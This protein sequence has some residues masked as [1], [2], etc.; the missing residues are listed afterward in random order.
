MTSIEPLLPLTPSLFSNEEWK[1]I[2]ALLARLD[3]S[4]RLWLSGYLLS[5]K[6]EVFTVDTTAEA[7]AQSHMLV[8][9]GT[10]TGN[11]K[12]LAHQLAEQATRAGSSVQLV[13]LA[14]YRFRQLMHEEMLFIICSTHG[15]GDAPEPIGEFYAALMNE[16][17]ASLH[18]LTFAVL[19]LGDTSYPLFCE[20]G[21]NIEQRL[22]QLGAKPAI[23]RVDCDVDYQEAAEQWINQVIEHLPK[24]PATQT[25]TE[26]A[27]TPVLT[28]DA[29][30]E[31]SK[32]NPCVAKVIENIP[33]T[34]TTSDRNVHHLELALPDGNLSLK[35]GDAIGI[36]AHNSNS[37]ITDIFQLTGLDETADVIINQ[38]S[39]TL[40]E[41]LQTQVDLVIPGKKFL[42]TWAQWCQDPA[43][44]KVATADFTEQRSFLRN[45]QII[46]ILLEYPAAPAAQEF[47][48]IL[49]PLQ[50]RLYD[51]ANHINNDHE[52]HIL[53]KQY[54][55]PFRNR[56]EKGMASTWL[57]TLAAEDTVLIYPHVNKK[58]HLPTIENL[59]LIFIGCDTGVAPYRSF[60]QALKAQG[61]RNP[62][63]LILDADLTSGEI[64][65]Q[66]DWLGARTQGSLVYVD[67]FYCAGNPVAS[68]ESILTANSI[69]LLEWIL[70]GAH[71]YLCGDRS[72]LHPCEKLLEKICTDYGRQ[73]KMPEGFSWLQLVKQERIHLNLY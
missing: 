10:E 67:P 59:P 64:L 73:R 31:Y 13:N 72:V 32:N 24:T 33:L 22:I 23:A 48:D 28:Q 68:V 66:L 57:T 38:R 20:A 9:Y 8:A 62:C 65:Y 55:Y 3:N 52:I 44:Q 34:E 12:Q 26:Q 54:R 36:F 60:L 49:R 46:D 1:Q 47:V 14:E 25:G 16:K 43:L 7:V 51:L 11:S 37:L 56:E 35:A 15:D 27:A 21:K 58:F 18:H 45:H 6:G 2:N 41:A 50:P 69:R 17:T 61:C 5:F 70:M 40:R 63:W 53:V 29:A 19:A 71:I 42:T 4:Q 39:M 30:E